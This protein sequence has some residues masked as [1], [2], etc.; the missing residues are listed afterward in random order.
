MPLPLPWWNLLLDGKL[1]HLTL[2]HTTYRSISSLKTAIYREA[3][4]RGIGVVIHQPKFED[5]LLVQA[6]TPNKAG[7]SPNSPDLRH[8]HGREASIEMP[9]WGETV[10]FLKASAS[11]PSVMDPVQRF[12][13]LRQMLV[14]PQPRSSGPAPE[15]EDPDLIQERELC[16]CGLGNASGAQVHEP[17]CKVWG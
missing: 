16:T 4:E 2:A 1:H 15:V 11:R 6:W 5:L 10:D 7:Y 14:L 12:Q 13:Q 17:S 3:S 9:T 8:G